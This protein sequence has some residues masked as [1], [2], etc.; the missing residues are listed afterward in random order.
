MR[1]VGSSRYK[2]M[3][4]VFLDVALV[5]FSDAANADLRSR[6]DNNNRLLTSVTKIYHAVVWAAAFRPAGQEKDD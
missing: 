6:H 2:F 1:N 3:R 4:C 5:F